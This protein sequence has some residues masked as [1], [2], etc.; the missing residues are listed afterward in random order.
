MLAPV[1]AEIDARDRA[2]EERQHGRGERVR[3]AGHRDHRAVV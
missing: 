3:V 1:L 2:L